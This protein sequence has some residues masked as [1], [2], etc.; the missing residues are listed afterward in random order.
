MKSTAST[1]EEAHTIPISTPREIDQAE[2][3][4][5]TTPAR[6]RFDV[7]LEVAA[8]AAVEVAIAETTPPAAPEAEALAPIVLS[9]T[10]KTIPESLQNLTAS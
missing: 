7:G 3:E 6:A 10:L 8:G 9:A 5:P 4:V 2:E 1:L